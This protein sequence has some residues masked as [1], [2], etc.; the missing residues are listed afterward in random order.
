MP[1]G[2]KGVREIVRNVQQTMVRAGGGRGNAPG[3][4]AEIPCSP[5]RR[6]LCLLPK[7]YEAS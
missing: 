4:Q 1:R 6:P 2:Q 5:W 7:S 3:K